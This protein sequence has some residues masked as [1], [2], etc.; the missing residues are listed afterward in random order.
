MPFW[1]RTLRIRKLPDSREK[2]VYIARLHFDMGDHS[3]AAELFGQLYEH[4]GRAPLNDEQTSRVS[5]ARYIIE[6]LAIGSQERAASQIRHLTALA[7]GLDVEGGLNFAAHL[8]L[9]I[10]ALTVKP[11]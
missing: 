11:L 7:R 1:W 10:E 5:D 6:L 9:E 2:D 8:K 3:R 4:E